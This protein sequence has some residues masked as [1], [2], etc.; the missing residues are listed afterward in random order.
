MGQLALE[1]EGLDALGP[2]STQLLV[3]AISAEFRHDG[4]LSI[5][6]SELLRT[7]CGVPGPLMRLDAA[8]RD[9]STKVAM[10]PLCGVRIM[11]CHVPP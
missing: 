5:S 1:G 10:T 11:C 9:V 3:E 2:L 6:V 7:I 8:E 4:H